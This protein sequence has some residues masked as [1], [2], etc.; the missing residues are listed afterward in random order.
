MKGPRGGALLED[1]SNGVRVFLFQSF[2]A[3]L[4]ISQ[5]FF[6]VTHMRVYLLRF[7]TQP[8][9]RSHPFPSRRCSKS[10]PVLR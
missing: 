10:I 2:I 8:C 4:H 7:L 3:S 6:P 1:Y 5:E 9:D